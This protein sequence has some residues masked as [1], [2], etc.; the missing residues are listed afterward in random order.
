LSREVITPFYRTRAA[1]AIEWIK[2]ALEG[3]CAYSIHKPEGALF[4]WIWFKDLPVTTMELY[5]RLKTRDV[6][7]IPGR[8]F[9]FGLTERWKHADECIRINYSQDENEVREGIRRIGE[10]VG[11]LV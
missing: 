7:V 11:E 5:N 8:H 1:Q 6:L 10:V 9:F 3:V 4:L 2:E